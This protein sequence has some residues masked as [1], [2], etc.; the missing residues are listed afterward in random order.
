MA[1]PKGK[2]VHCLA[3]DVPLNSDHVF[4][5][6]WY[7]EGTEDNKYKRQ[8]PSCIKCNNDYGRMEK[9]LLIRIGLCL[10][11]DSEES[12]GI[13]DKA[14][15]AIDPTRG[16]NSKDAKHRQKKREQIIS[17]MMRE[18]DVPPE[19]IYPEF[20]SASQGAIGLP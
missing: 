17:Q 15:R 12:K 19:S 16:R 9:D 14:M 4:P 13:I 2:C 18:E 20:D 3:D 11:P 6:S 5:E 8:I 7:P 1:K 10:N